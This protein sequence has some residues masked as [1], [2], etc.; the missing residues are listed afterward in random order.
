MRLENITI[1][2]WLEYFRELLTE[3]RPYY[4]EIQE[5]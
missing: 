5:E 4:M 3:A 1:G 2:D